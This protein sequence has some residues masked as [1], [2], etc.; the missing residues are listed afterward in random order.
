MTESTLPIRCLILLITCLTS[1]QL[2][3]Q[4]EIEIQ[5]GF[6]IALE[7]I[8][9]AEGLSQGMVNDMVM[10]ENGYLWIATKDGLNRYDGSKM[11]VFRHDPAD[12]LSLSDDFVFSLCIDTRGQLWVGTQSRGV[13]LF[14]PETE[15]FIRINT[16]A[17]EPKRISSD[18]VGI[19]QAGPNG[20]V[21]IETLDDHGYAYMSCERK[22][23]QHIFDVRP[24]ADVIPG[25]LNVKTAYKWTKYLTFDHEDNLWYCNGDSICKLDQRAQLGETEPAYYPYPIRERISDA[26]S[27]ILLTSPDRKTIYISDGKQTLKCYNPEKD[28][29][30]PCAI[31]PSEYSFK[32][33]QFIDKEGLLWVWQNDHT[34][35]RIDMEAKKGITL[36]PKWRKVDDGAK[37]HRG[38]RIEDK[39]GNF[40][41]GTGGNG[42][43]KINTY[44][45]LFQHVG[46]DDVIRSHDIRPHRIE[47]SGAN[48]IFDQEI[49]D[50]WFE[51]MENLDL[52]SKGYKMADLNANL[53]YDNDGYFWYSAKSIKNTDQSVIRINATTSEFE[54]IYSKSHL[55]SEWFGS[56]LFVDQNGEVWWGEKFSGESVKLYHYNSFGI[57]EEHEFPVKA[58]KHQYRFISDVLIDENGVFW[59]GTT[60]GVFS[61]HP[62]THVWTHFS[63]ASGQSGTNEPWL[64][65]TLEQDVHDPEII[66]VGTSGQGVKKF[67]KREQLV[68]GE[69]GDDVLPNLVVYGIQSDRSG[70]LWISTN[71][72]ITW[73]NQR[74]GSVQVF[75]QEH[76]LP[77]NEFNR[78]EYS[79][80]AQGELYF[81]GMNG[82]VHFNPES[83]FAI[84]S[85]PKVIINSL[86]LANEPI[87]Y[88][89]QRDGLLSKPIERIDR[90]DLPYNFNMV[91]LGFTTM[92]LTAPVHDEFKYKLEEV[93][94]DWIYTS[95]SQ[96]AVYTSLDPGTYT[97][98]VQGKNSSN[99]WSTQP[100]KLEIC[101]LAPWW[102][103]WWFQSLVVLSIALAIYLLYRYRVN[104][105]LRIERLRNRIAQDLHDD[106]GSTLSSISIYSTVLRRKVKE[107]NSS[108]VLDKISDSTKEIMEKMNDIV[109]TIKTDNDGFDKVINRMRAFSVNMTEHKDMQLVFQAD[110]N[111]MKL[112]LSMEDR[113]NVYLIFKEAVNNAVKY[114]EAK[115][116]Q[117]L[118][119]RKGQYVDLQVIDNGIGISSH[120]EQTKDLLLGGNGLKGMEQRSDELRGDLKIVDNPEGGTIVHLRFLINRH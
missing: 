7:S 26:N 89:H 112:K 13:N 39:N 102:L 115:Q 72:G 101:V 77:G 43:L 78:Y 64:V 56:T 91:S 99:V 98:L 34:V 92:D 6:E 81:G 88:N 97:F 49:Y 37:N 3:G 114:S 22:N 41:I 9:T 45:L 117:V 105:L 15:T 38:I 65:L 71:Y 96:P 87:L 95:S 29:F 76:G 74:D 63:G 70:G 67:N 23:G 68:E 104:Q 28:V 11:T 25:I 109:W 103:S 10:D 75:T 82:V 83:F 2:T 90:V 33:F 21:Y 111:V 19:M 84:Q 53:V 93:N 44:S 86:A 47:V 16:K 18:F 108:L 69:L 79:S 60:Q 5:Q 61:F 113:K 30:E 58:Q 73:Y 54:I 59:L 42:L 20:E 119:T 32:L 120:V 107:Q 12:S 8:G 1:L 62:K 51:T 118:V 50:L 116:I 24:I 55:E 85:S 17:D 31:L 40:W 80:T 27:Q 36:M 57:V 48:S 106:I 110:P 52:S 46:M 4:K 35:C 94:D 66:W 100:T 14:V